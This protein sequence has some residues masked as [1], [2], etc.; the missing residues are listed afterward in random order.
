MSFLLQ[1]L[2]GINSQPNFWHRWWRGDQ[3]RKSD[4]AALTAAKIAFLALL[5][6]L[7]AYIVL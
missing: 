7:S 3:R 6:I 2:G 4:D 5:L 1:W